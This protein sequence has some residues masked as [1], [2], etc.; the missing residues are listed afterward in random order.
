[1]NSQYY[2]IITIVAL[3][4]SFIYVLIKYLYLKGALKAIKS[5]L[6]Y[7]KDTDTNLL[8][9]SPSKHPDLIAIV[10]LMNQSLQQI[11]ELKQSL[12]R[13]EIELRNTIT[14][15]SHD[16][17][18]PIT[19]IVG[20]IQLLRKEKALSE[21]EH[22]YLTIIESRIQT[23]RV[24]VE[25]LFQYSL[26]Y[27]QE[28]PELKDDDILLVLEDA[29][30]LFYK[31]FEAK[32]IE[33]QLHLGDKPL[34][35]PIDRLSLKRVFMNIINNAIKHGKGEIIIQVNE[36]QIIFKNKA[37]NVDQIDIGKLFHRF[38]TVAK[39]VKRNP[40]DLVSPSQNYC[41]K[42]WAIGLPLKSMGNTYNSY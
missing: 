30:L 9:D 17:R 16:L 37:E 13:E 19:S 2:F 6:H 41:S 3:S 24:L 29:V 36:H 39:P 27:E 8:I 33:L 38:F 25:Q 11:N 4:T 15:L 34:I 40:M 31:E 26:I 28:F 35:R 22:E 20:Y 21:K 1:M 5:R 7:I 14:N 10:S 23:L 42:K 18:T 12:I 32:K